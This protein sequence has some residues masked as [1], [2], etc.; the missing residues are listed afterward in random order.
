ML[1]KTK[2]SE[3]SIMKLIDQVSY[4]KQVSETQTEGIK[5]ILKYLHS[6]K[7]HGVDNNYVNPSDIV[8]MLLNIRAEVQTI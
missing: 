1:Y 5:D 3:V 2:E 4:Y 6:E 8:S 7:F